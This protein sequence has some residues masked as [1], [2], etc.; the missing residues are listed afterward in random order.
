VHT[1]T[2]VLPKQRGQPSHQ[3]RRRLVRS[4]LPS[5][6]R[7]STGETRAAAAARQVAMA[8][9]QGKRQVA[10]SHCQT[11]VKVNGLRPREQLHNHSFHHLH[12][13]QRYS[14]IPASDAV[15]SVVSSSHRDHR[16]D[17]VQP[18]HTHAGDHRIASDTRRKLAPNTR[19]AWSWSLTSSSSH[20]LTQGLVPRWYQPTVFVAMFSLVGLS[21]SHKTQNTKH[22]GTVARWH[23][24]TVVVRGRCLVVAIA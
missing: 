3:S 16:L 13:K 9:Y 24:G 10:W 17:V 1:W 8:H 22:A 7:V 20:S 6:R 5:R 14:H 21:S 2:I 19:L 23:G 15:W 4:K 11:L 18:T 12:R